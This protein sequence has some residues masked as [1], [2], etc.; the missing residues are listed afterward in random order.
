VNN[1]KLK[2]Y[3]VIADFEQMLIKHTYQKLT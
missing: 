1:S 2:S 3:E